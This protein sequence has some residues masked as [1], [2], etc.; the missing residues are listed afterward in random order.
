MS[1]KAK[2]PDNL[3][4]KPGVYIMRDNTDTIIYIGKAKSLV[5]RVKS[6]FREKLDRPKTQILM[7]HFHSLEY[8]ITNSEKEALILE[9]N[10]I[11]KH[12]PRY[13]IQ[14]KDDKRYPYVKIT[15]EEYPRLVITRNVTK[16]GVY[17][18]P[19]TDVGSVKRT[20][21][22][23]KSLFKI[24]TCRNMNGPCLN[25]Q[26]DLCYAP[27][28]GRISKKQYSE[29]INKID[30]FF[31]GKYSVIV[32]NLKKEMLE[33][34]D[35][36]EFEK[37][38]VIRD[39]ISSI[40]EIMEKQFVELA[41]DDLDQDVIAMALNK[42][43]VIVI[44]M[45]IRNGKIVGRDDFLMSSSK[46]DS[47]SEVMFAFIQQYYGYN[48]HVPKQ[49]L[50]EDDIDE[51]DLL[52]DWLS[53]LRGNKVKIKVPQKGVKL[54]LV[55]MA[56]KNAE[57]IKHQKKNMDNSLMELKKYLKLEKVPH[58]IEGYDISNIS[59]KFA[60][61][62]KVSFK[63][64]KPNK[65]MY[66]R[67]K[68]ETPGPN[69]FA[70]M[71]ELLTRRLK[72]IDKDP[73][74]DLIVIDGGKGQLGMACGVLEK[75]NLTHIPIIG[76]AKEFEEI[77][78]PNSKRPIIIPKNNIALHLLQQVRDESHR[79]AITYHRKL[80]SDNIQAS[81]LDDIA[82]IGKKRKISLLKEFGSVD[83]IKKASVGELAKIDNMNQKTAENVYNYYH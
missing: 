19:F 6:Y 79:F 14:L 57:I 81:S 15:D 51:K 66:K 71:E 34:A 26:I 12:R 52:E 27:C 3:P 70:M 53:D 54:R 4:N 74:P 37:A 30:L 63:D 69:D 68:M 38:A 62:S 16:N 45:P 9:A 39:Q 82:G 5:K 25:S 77:Y 72:M 13:N 56:K 49:I 73:E 59:G 1:T 43:E 65:K 2:S 80:R 33:A 55:K 83:N 24:R 20:V 47:A 78:L 18:G 41:N 29:I 10:L 22:F 42:N 40:E 48:R 75:L 36:E 7:S 50:L 35:N 11:K 61:G 76:L 44:I 21:K 46:Y 58:V 8:I 67:F 60:V 28:D 32:K 64:G 31:Q 23:L 17:F